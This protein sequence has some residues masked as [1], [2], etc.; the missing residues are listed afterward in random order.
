MNSFNS[1]LSGFWMIA[2]LDRVFLAA[3]FPFITLTISCH[4]L[5]AC[6]ISAEKPANGLMGVSFYV[7][8]SLATFKII[9]IFSYFIYYFIYFLFLF[10]FCCFNYCVLVWTYLGYI[11]GSFLCLLNL[12]LS[13]FRKFSAIIYSNT[14][15]PPSFSLFLLGSIECICYYT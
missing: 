9:T 10:I 14:P 3:D 12:F 13:R 6:K 2:L 5:L 8:V 1:C 4:S 15:L 11:L 7:I